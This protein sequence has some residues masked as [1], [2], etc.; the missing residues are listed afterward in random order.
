MNI[1]VINSGSS[2]VK[3]KLFDIREEKEL[4]RGAIERIGLKRS[5]LSHKPAGKEEI[6][7]SKEVLDHDA[8]IK[9]TLDFLTHEEHGVIKGISEIGAVGHR[10]VHGGEEFSDSTIITDEVIRVIK[11]Y[12]K[13]APLHNPA[14]LLG[15]R[16]AQ[17]LLPG[18]KHIA[19]FDTAFH[20]TIPPSAYLYGLPYSFYEKER[21]R[22]YGFHGTSHKYVALRAAEILAKPLA[23]LKII[24][25]HLGNG[26][27]V[28]AVKNGKSINTSMGFTPLE[29]LLM[30]TR[31]GDVDPAIIFYLMRKKNLLAEDVDNLLNKKSGLLGMSGVSSDMRD[32]YSELRKGNK[33]AKFAFEIFIDRIQKYVGSCIVAMDGAD[34]IVFTAGIGE[35]HAPTRSAV[36][37]KLSFLGVKIDSRK[38]N[39]SIKEKI[40]TTDDSKVRILVVPTNEEL[41]IARET[42]RLAPQF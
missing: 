7:T 12:F 24:T 16:V 18:I 33:K 42:H 2:S 8:A 11:S 6:K 29:G 27:S 20:Q 3:Y 15:I 30:G 5:I 21:I 4:A 1:L 37:E 35:N 34:A 9:L 41:M 17:K 23:E 14:N 40:I 32:V 25:C 22:K 13:L 38:N 28:T 31:S 26:C 19:V 36:C 39:S 10:V